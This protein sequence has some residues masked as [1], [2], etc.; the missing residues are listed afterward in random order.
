MRAL[1]TGI[2]A[3]VAVLSASCAEGAGRW[4]LLIKGDHVTDTVIAPGVTAYGSWAATTALTYPE[5]FAQQGNPGDYGAAQKAILNWDFVPFQDFTGDM[6]VGVIAFHVPTPADYAAGLT[7]GIAKVTCSIDNGAWAERTVETTNPDTGVLDFNFIARASTMSDGPHELRCVAFPRTGFPRVL[8]G[9][10]SWGAPVFSQV[11]NANSGGTLATSTVHVAIGGS[12]SVCSAGAPCA[13]VEAAALRC[14]STMPG[15]DVGGC[16]IKVAAGTYTLN[17]VVS[18]AKTAVTRWTKITHEDGL[19]QSDV[20]FNDTTTNGMVPRIWHLWLQDV[21]TTFGISGVGDAQRANYSA[22]FDHVLYVSR[23][24]TTNTSQ[25]ENSPLFGTAY[26]QGSW[27]TDGDYSNSR[28]G[29][30]SGTLVRNTY[31]HTLGSDSFTNMKT[32]VNS[33]ARNFIFCCSYHP[34]VWQNF[35]GTNVPPNTNTTLTDNFIA[36]GLTADTGDMQGVM[37]KEADFA[38]IAMVN[39]NINTTQNSRYN[40]NLNCNGIASTCT[41]VFTLDSSFIAGGANAIDNATTVVDSAFVN[42]TLTPDI[43]AHAGVERLP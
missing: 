37:L 8:Q 31:V 21:K 35:Q 2:L 43:P 12:G 33:T 22:W 1:W 26:G 6:H 20:V 24:G 9:A 39:V 4:S 32:V 40:L 38:N 36:Y 5:A 13:T 23:L 34:D 28:D 17:S 16:I 41:H 27:H 10:M 18:T 42:T 11:I 30:S 25:T 3:A 14:R 19:S 29:P 15:S 7:R